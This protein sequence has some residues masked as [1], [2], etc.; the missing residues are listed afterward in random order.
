VAISVCDD[1]FSH[2]MNKYKTTIEHV[3]DIMVVKP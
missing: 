3:S 2:I 1:W